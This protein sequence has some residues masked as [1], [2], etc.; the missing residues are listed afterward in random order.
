MCSLFFRLLLQAAKD[1]KLSRRFIWL[2]SDSWA[3]NDYVVGDGLESV[4]SGAITIQ[5]RSLPLDGF[6][7]YVKSL[8]L[9]KHDPIPDDWFEEFYQDIHRCRILRSV[10]QRNYNR[11][12][13]GNEKM[14][15]SMLPRDPFIFHTILA[16]DMIALGLNNIKKVTFNKL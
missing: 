10:V 2:G 14:T 16:V 12:C 8:T 5:I 7:Q 11:L 15:D 13:T 3:N 4:A 1:L 9:A 6:T